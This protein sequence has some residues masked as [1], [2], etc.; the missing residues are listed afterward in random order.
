M[1]GHWARFAE[2]AGVTVGL[3]KVPAPLVMFKARLT[4][5]PHIQSWFS[6]FTFFMVLIFLV[7]LR[8]KARNMILT[9]TL[10]NT[11]LVACFFIAIPNFGF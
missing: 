4:Q 1:P 2:G 11:R 10:Y 8:A 3:V 6:T 5:N 9:I 7:V